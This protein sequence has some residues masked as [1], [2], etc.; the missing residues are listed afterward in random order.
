MFSF[1][2]RPSRSQG[3]SLVELLVVLTVAAILLS[4]AI[5]GVMGITRGYQLTTTSDLLLNQFNLARQAALSNSHLVQVRIYH[6]PD[7]N[8]EPTASRTTY[9]A[10]QCFTEGDPGSAGTP[11]LTP[12]TKTVFFPTPVIISTVTSPNLSPLLTGTTGTLTSA[13]SSDPVLAVYGSNYDYLWFHFK[14]NGTT[15]L[16]TIANSFTL[17]LENDASAA[18]GLPHNYRTIEIDPAIGTSRSFAP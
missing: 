8:A 5:P 18:T 15:D 11:P 1:F 2:P 6:L 4:L 13:G 12:L 9:R 3:F 14:P 16:T 7:Y 17:I 10:I